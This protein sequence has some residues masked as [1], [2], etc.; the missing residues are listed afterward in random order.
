MKYVKPSM[1][2]CYICSVITDFALSFGTIPYVLFPTM[3]GQPL[4]ILSYLGIDIKSQTL[5]IIELL[6]GVACSIIGIL[7]NRFTCITRPRSSLK[8]HIIIYTL[9]GVYSNIILYFVFTN[10]PEQQSARQIVLYQLLPS[11]LPSH[12]YTDPLFVV[13][14]NSFQVGM[15]ILAIYVVLFVECIFFALG[16]TYKLYLQ[17]NNTNLSS[18]TRKMQN[19]FFILI[20]IQCSIPITVLAIPVC[21]VI[22]SCSTSYFNQALNNLAFILFSFHGILTSI[23]IILIHPAYREA[24]SLKKFCLMTIAS[25]NNSWSYF[26]TPEFLVTSL[27]IL[28][29]IAI[30]IHL[31]GFYCVFF[32]T[33]PK[34]RYVKSSMIQCFLSGAVLDFAFS[35]GTIP[36]ALL[37][38]LS[39]HFLG[40]L[41]DLGMSQKSQVILIIELI[42]IVG[43]SLIG[44]LENRFTCI[45]NRRSRFKNN[46]LIYLFNGSF[47]SFLVYLT[48]SNCP[49]QEEARRI[50]LYEI[51]PPNLP[52]HF[53]TDP[54][55]VISLQNDQIATTM[56]ISFLY[57]FITCCGFVFGTFYKLYYLEKNRNLS[58]ITKKMMIK[59]FILICIQCSIP[60]TVLAFPISYIAFSCSTLYFNQALN[61]LI[62]IIFS[63][64]G[65]LTTLSIICIH[66]EY[67]RVVFSIFKPPKTRVQS[68][69]T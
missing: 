6:I 44:I 31:L 55:F 51:L 23:S 64:H 39:G 16:T 13:S 18:N 54:I 32:K 52:A 17:H 56:M 35:F 14:L 30:P 49:E 10:C 7:E 3:S 22:I 67:R 38:T 9:N 68:V 50:V 33:P 45:T 15:A 48:F 29:I 24:Q 26:N 60:L 8:N 47:L 21:Y 69:F 57:T 36:Y 58:K 62:F 63:F 5:L 19:K 53:Y 65:I 12:F 1:I 2:Q 25:K 61:N 41:S 37:P 43:C 11:D 34:M 4:G 66:T 46:F 59:F 28:T 42:L 27:H 40:V 20:C